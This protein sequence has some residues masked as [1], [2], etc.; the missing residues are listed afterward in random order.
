M[1]CNKSV[2]LRKSPSRVFHDVEHYTWYLYF[3]LLYM[4]IILYNENNDIIAGLQ[5]GTEPPPIRGCGKF[6]L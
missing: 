3:M 4:Y 1:K 6:L 2:G 5:R